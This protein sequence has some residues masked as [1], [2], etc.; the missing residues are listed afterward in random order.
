MAELI[1][2]SNP[3]DQ[4]S[5]KES[6][7]SVHPEKRGDLDLVTPWKTVEDLERAVRALPPRIKIAIKEEERE[8]VYPDAERDSLMT[9]YDKETFKILFGSNIAIALDRHLNFSEQWYERLRRGEDP[10]ALRYETVKEIDLFYKEQKPPFFDLEY[11]AKRQD[12]AKAEYVKTRKE[13]T[14]TKN[15]LVKLEEAIKSLSGKRGSKNQMRELEAERDKLREVVSDNPQGP[16]KLSRL[17]IKSDREF[18][19]LQTLKSSYDDA[20][21]IRNICLQNR[22]RITSEDAADIWAEVADRIGRPLGFASGNLRR[23]GKNNEA[24]K[25][26]DYRLQI[27]EIL[28]ESVF[29]W[30]ETQPAEGTRK[31]KTDVLAKNFFLVRGLLETSLNRDPESVRANLQHAQIILRRLVDLAG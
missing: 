21:R 7:S 26:E 11:L 29:D 24:K 14:E 20:D 28:L 15:K 13:Y 9:Q 18:A 31:K 10:G 3:F 23:K 16:G 17:A 19:N 25:I 22:Q 12:E 4:E 5:K 6:G 1:L 27:K 30:L 8:E 2:S